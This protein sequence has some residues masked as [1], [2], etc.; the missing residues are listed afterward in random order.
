MELYLFNPEKASKEYLIYI[1]A[2]AA[3]IIDSDSSQKC[4]TKIQ[5]GARMGWKPK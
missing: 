2:G 1:S 5:K 3:E 4:T